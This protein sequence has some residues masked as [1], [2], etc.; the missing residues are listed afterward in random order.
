[1]HVLTT[2]T[3]R[4]LCYL[5]F[6]RLFSTKTSFFL[7]VAQTKNS[8]CTQ[9]VLTNFVQQCSFHTRIS[10]ELKRLTLTNSHAFIQYTF[11]FLPRLGQSN[12]VKT[13]K[14]E[15]RGQRFSLNNIE[16]TQAITLLLPCLQLLAKKGVDFVVQIK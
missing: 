1:M 4:R 15:F 16:L 3:L 7:R 6:S 2:E 14:N 10:F 8:F 11:I 9:F 13:N 12:V 5:G